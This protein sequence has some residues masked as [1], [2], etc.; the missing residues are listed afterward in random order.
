MWDPEDG[1]HLDEDAAELC[2]IMQNM[3]DRL[4]TDENDGEALAILSR[5][6]ELLESMGYIRAFSV[7]TM[8]IT[9]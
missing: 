1:P 7:G 3:V 4:E 8:P 9:E 5:C 6:E 2:D